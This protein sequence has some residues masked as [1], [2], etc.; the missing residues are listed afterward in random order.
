M[1]VVG[2]GLCP[3]WQQKPFIGILL[4]AVDLDQSAG[5]WCFCSAEISSYVGDRKVRSSKTRITAAVRIAKV[6][7]VL[8]LAA[9][10]LLA[11]YAAGV[12]IGGLI[13]V[14]PA[15][16]AQGPVQ[17]SETQSVFD[18]EA[19]Q[20][21]GD[22][23]TIFFLNNKYHVEICLPA[24]L[25]PFRE[26]IL[27]VRGDAGPERGYYCFGWGD[28]VF[29]PVTPFLED[30]NFTLVTRSLFLPTDAA[31]RISFYDGPISGEIVTPYRTSREHVERLYEFISTYLERDEEG[32]L[33]VIPPETVNPVYGDSLFVNAAGTYSLFFTCNNWS[34]KALKQAGLETGLW[35]PLAWKVIPSETPSPETPSSETP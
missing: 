8:L 11:L 6:L 24:S 7:A 5:V 19:G 10:S 33:A 20:E 1:V 3:V 16:A 34:A 30:L 32:R 14:N 9:A 21:A 18:T 4:Q 13:R 27:E 23:Y 15:E 2:R 35:T 28:R 22:E 31:V 17:R 25:S 26:E 12:L 29:Y